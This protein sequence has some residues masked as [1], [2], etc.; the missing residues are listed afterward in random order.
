MAIFVE[1]ATKQG[2][3]RLMDSML[4]WISK[5]G[6]EPFLTHRLELV[7]EEVLVNIINHAFNGNKGQMSIECGMDAHCVCIRF[8]DNGRPFDPTCLTEPDVTLSLE[9][10]EIGGL[11]VFLVKEMA[12]QISYRRDGSENILEIKMNRFKMG[13]T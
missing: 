13:E 10:R 12:D 9:N 1:T 11:G 8:K 6:V 2:L 3:A 7:T 5:Q 4:S